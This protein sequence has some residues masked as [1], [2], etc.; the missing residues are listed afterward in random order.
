M[1]TKVGIIADVE[2][3]P[4]LR[5]LEVWSTKTMIERVKDRFGIETKKLIG[6]TAYGTAKFLG[7]MVNEAKIE[8]HVPVWDKG[9]GKDG[10]FEGPMHG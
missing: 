8:P 2:A 4:T 6:D 9:E 1:D 5:T 7:W 3:T 10:R